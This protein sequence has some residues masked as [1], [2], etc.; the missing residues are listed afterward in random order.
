[1]EARVELVCSGDRTWTSCTH[2]RTCVR[3]ANALTNRASHT[4]NDVIIWQ[5]KEIESLFRRHFPLSPMHVLNWETEQSR[6]ALK[7]SEW[8]SVLSYKILPLNQSKS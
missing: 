8:S 5:E 2:E 4:D 3:A 1:M 6:T 7:D